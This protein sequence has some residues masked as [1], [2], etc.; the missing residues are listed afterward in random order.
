MPERL[1]IKN[2]I[3]EAYQLVI[4]LSQVVANAGIDSLQQELIKIRA[5]QINGCAF[6]ID[7][8]TNEAIKKGEDPRR[9][10]VLSAWR[11]ARNWFSIE[12]QVILKLTEEITLIADRGLSDETYEQAVGY[13]GEMMTAKL[14]MAVI[15]INSL[16]R[17]GIS[18]RLHPIA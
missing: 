3:P 1:M 2:L 15:N 13:F 9:L 14:I 12:D 7:V 5:S 6:C 16:N 8:H 10:A 17:M 4:Q 18:Q 11:E